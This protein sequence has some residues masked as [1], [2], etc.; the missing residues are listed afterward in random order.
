M[1]GQVPGG[2]SPQPYP[3]QAPAPS[4]VVP[5]SGMAVTALVLGIIALLAAFIPFVNVVSF[6]AGGLA[7]IFGIIA[8]VTADGVK[9]RGRG[10]GITGLILGAVAILVA[11]I[12]IVVTTAFFTAVDD[13]LTVDVDSSTAG[14]AEGTPSDPLPFPSEITLENGLVV[15]VG[16]PTTIKPSNTAAVDNKQTYFWAVEVSITNNGAETMNLFGTSNGFTSTGA[17]CD[18][19]FDSQQ[20]GDQLFALD[21]SLPPGKTVKST[22]AFQCPETGDP[23]LELTPDIL[24]PTLYYAG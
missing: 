5:M 22:L 12:V 11:I 14:G 2:Y 15:N 16:T 1:S 17:T 13:A 10:M 18:S 21:G 8:V 3:Q 20:F 4:G 23:E 6:I 19:L 9:R 24:G 7:I